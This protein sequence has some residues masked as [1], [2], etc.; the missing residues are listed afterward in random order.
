MHSLYV[1]SEYM[2]R[3]GP[4]YCG[5]STKHAVYMLVSICTFVVNLQVRLMIS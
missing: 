1:L 4:K 3:A 2:M 5:F